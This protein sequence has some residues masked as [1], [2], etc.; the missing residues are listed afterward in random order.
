MIVFEGEQPL[1]FVHR[2][3]PRVRVVLAFASAVVVCLCD[4]AAVLGV[5]LGGAL[6]LVVMARIAHAQMLRRLVELNLF[7]LLLVVFLPVTTPGPAALRIDG[8]AWS[9]E[10]I[11]LAVRVALKANAIMIAFIAL[12]G[13]MEPAYLGFALDRLGIPKKLTHILLFMVR[14]IEVIHH[15]F[16]RLFNAMRLRGFRPGFNRH[17]FRAYGYL[18]GM[19]L[20][21]SLDR[22]ERVV[23][24]MKCRGFRGRFYVLARFQ[25]AAPDVL[26]AAALTAGLVLLGCMEWA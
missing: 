23:A 16:H 14:Y 10:G 3:D 24:A 17:T 11:R 5:G 8:L 19:L 9:S 2:V 7:M 22:A 4:R 26:F 6:L 25:I 21:R 1:S 18:V 13:T 20:V 12:L 15:E